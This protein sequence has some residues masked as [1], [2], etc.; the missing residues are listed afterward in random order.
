[1]AGSLVIAGFWLS[2]ISWWFLL[3]TALGTFGPGVLREMGLLRDKD[4]F[5][6]RAEHRAGY[7]AFL[8]TGLVAFLL[9]AF[10]RSADRVV[11]NP[12][13]LATLFLVLLWFTWMLSSLLSFW[14]TRIASARMLKVFGTVVL[15]FTIVSNVGSEWDGW[16][17]LL[18]H[19]LLSLPFFVLAW[20]A[21]KRPRLSGVLL[22]G[23]SVFFL[24][25]FG[26]FQKDP[27][28]LV[29]DGVVFVLFLGPLLASGVALLCSGEAD[30]DP[31][32]ET[33]A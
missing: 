28:R 23:C 4:E 19:P 9:V 26:W 1:V 32:E 17:P 33:T 22:L 31:D 12:Q 30:Q 21:G 6:Q 7:H 11:R 13:E 8:A 15:V 20:L 14:G 5:Q 18:L 10:F 16:A 24:R 3:L 29:D 27:E 25:F 2:G